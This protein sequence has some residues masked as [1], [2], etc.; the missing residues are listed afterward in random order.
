MNE[1]EIWKALYYDNIKPDMYE[2]SNMGNIRNK[3]TDK[4]L[5]LC[6]SEKGYMMA[7]LRCCNNKTRSIK[8]HR[9]VAKLFVPG[10]T[11]EKCEVDHIN[12]DKRDNRASN[13]RWVTHLENIRY[14]YKNNLI[15]ILR[16]EQNSS[17][18]VTEKEVREIC[19]LLVS[20]N[21]NVA[22]VH[23]YLQL[24]GYMYKKSY[25]QD[26]KLKRTWVHVSDNYFKKEDFKNDK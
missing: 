9:L 23:R 12:C 11:Q 14:A 10:E 24:K 21:G 4:Q 16:G 13:L 20:F 17:C 5:S 22:E 7:T 8:I 25:I 19:E 26:I 1:P 2:I 15:P 6:P 18:K 3:N